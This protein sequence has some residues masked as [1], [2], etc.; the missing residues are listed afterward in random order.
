MSLKKI[1]YS[2]WVDFGTSLSYNKIMMGKKSNNKKITILY[3]LKILKEG[4]NEN[5]PISQAVITKTINLLGIN[6]ERK[7][8]SR[9]IDC[10]IR[11]GYDI[12]KKKG[13]GCYFNSPEF[14]SNEIENLVKGINSNSV[15][16]IGEKMDLTRK[17]KK[18]I[19][20]NER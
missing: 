8:I 6:C 17:I 15:M 19:N 11:F 9:D 14:T 2:S 13:G 16:T 3:V 12:K 20:I 18:L 1:N 10:L 5:H 4:S 7:T